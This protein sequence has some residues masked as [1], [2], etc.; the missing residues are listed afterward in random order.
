[1]IKNLMFDLGGVI[2]E[3]DRM[4][5]VRALQAL[6]MRDVDKMLGDYG[7]T[8]P[9][10][11]LEKGEISPEEFHQEIHKLMPAGVT[12]DQIDEAFEKFLVGIPV[13]RLRK[14]EELH[15]D[16][17]IYLLSNTNK[18][19]WDGFIADEFRKDGHDMSYYFDGTVA[20]FEARAYKPDAEIF[21]IAER[22]FGIKPEETIFFDDS[23]ANCEAAAKLG[24]RTEWI[25]PENP[26]A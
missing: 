17:N 1:M 6:G 4:Q 12:D 9:F 26:I 15:K 7:Q 5:A 2:M 23:K 25:G 8:G 11:Q 13:E 22:R 20:S 3:I 16:Y 10:L 21:R 19:M 24:F 18:I 14:L